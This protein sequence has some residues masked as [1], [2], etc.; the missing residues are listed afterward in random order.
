M[1]MTSTGFRADASSVIAEVSGAEVLRLLPELVDVYRAAFTAA[2]YNE[3]ETS[4]ARFR[5]EQLAAHANREGFRCVVAREEGRIVGFAYGYTGRRGQWWS[6]HVAERVP[7]ELAERWLDGHFEF[8][9]L[10]VHPDQQGQG[11]G[12]AL[13]DALLAG[14]PHD[15]ALL[16]TWTRD[17]PAR[18]LYLNRGWQVLEQ[19]L[20]EN[21]SLLGLDLTARA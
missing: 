19:E 1:E 5:D 14:L 10:A 21:A 7:Q 20:W 15:R 6:D 3:D 8:V 4:V 11:I 16:S 17:Y 2:P 18:L 12:G 13:H 9:E